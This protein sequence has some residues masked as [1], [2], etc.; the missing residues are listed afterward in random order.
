M[1]A[2][3]AR[4]AVAPKWQRCVQQRRWHRA[5]HR[6]AALPSQKAVSLSP[7]PPEPAESSALPRRAEPRAQRTAPEQVRWAHALETRPRAR[8][9]AAVVVADA[10]SVEADAHSAAQGVH[11]AGA[12][13]S[14][15]VKRRRS[16]P[17]AESSTRGVVA[18]A[19]PAHAW[20]GRVAVLRVAALHDPPRVAAL[21]DRPE[22]HHERRRFPER[23]R[24]AVASSAAGAALAEAPRPLVEHPTNRSRRSTDG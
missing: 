8:Q 18:G 3:R 2:A 20:I 17:T 4:A 5:R 9:S 7:V 19:C 22:L 12:A 16:A 13:E 1:V 23:R 6:P 15:D 10:H 14:L 11:S 24:L 21:R